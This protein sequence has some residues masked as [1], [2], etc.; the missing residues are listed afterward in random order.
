FLSYDL[1]V[2][3][4]CRRLAKEFFEVFQHVDIDEP[5]V[6]F[7]RLRTKEIGVALKNGPH[8]KLQNFGEPFGNCITCEFR[9]L[10]KAWFSQG[11]LGRKR[12]ICDETAFSCL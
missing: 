8:D 11:F 7:Y 4:P 10:E 3:V 2:H 9:I 5:G 1:K 12:N 6:V